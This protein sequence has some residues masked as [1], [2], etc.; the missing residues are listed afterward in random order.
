MKYNITIDLNDWAFQDMFDIKSSSFNL[1]FPLGKLKA[2]RWNFRTTFTYMASKQPANDNKY[3][4]D[5]YELQTLSIVKK[6]HNRTLEIG[7]K[8]TNDEL[9]IKYNFTLFPEDP[10]VIKKRNNIWTFEGR[11]K[12]ASVERFK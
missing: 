7:Y 9:F 12:Q 4:L 5:Y 1:N 6:E 11:L 10:I 2:Y 8:K 3:V